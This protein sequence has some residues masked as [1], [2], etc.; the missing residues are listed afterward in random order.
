MQAQPGRHAKCD[1]IAVA[2]QIGDSW[3][4]MLCHVVKWCVSSMGAW[5]TFLGMSC[6][7]WS[8]INSPAALPRLLRVNLC[9]SAC[10]PPSPSDPC[11]SSPSVAM[12]MSPAVSGT[13]SD[14]SIACSASA[15]LDC[16]AGESCCARWAGSCCRSEAAGTVAGSDAAPGSDLRVI[17]CCVAA[18]SCPGGDGEGLWEASDILTSGSG[19]AEGGI[20][21]SG[22]CT[23]CSS[24]CGS[25][26]KPCWKVKCVQS[27]SSST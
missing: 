16:A 15:C 8:S 11:P 13:S 18:W 19:N 5:V 20:E 22:W 27:I 25:C 24:C 2:V 1:R 23:C 17:V 4:F 7:P 3:T 26:L 21:V 14:L 6:E 12:P 9:P 10:V